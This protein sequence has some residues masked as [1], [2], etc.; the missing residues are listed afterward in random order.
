MKTL[1]S[2]EETKRTEEAYDIISEN[3][4]NVTVVDDTDSD[5][6]IATFTVDEDFIQ[7]RTYFNGTTYFEAGDTITISHDE[8]FNFYVDD[9]S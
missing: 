1:N 5:F 8:D 6:I 7:N 2:Y 4:C 3:S 9:I